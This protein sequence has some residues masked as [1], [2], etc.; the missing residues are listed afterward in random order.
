MYSVQPSAWQE[1]VQSLVGARCYQ[2]ARA[3]T[4]YTHLTHIGHFQVRYSECYFLSF[5]L[6]VFLHVLPFVRRRRLSSPS[7]WWPAH[8]RRAVEGLA[9]G[10][11]LGKWIAP[12]VLGQPQ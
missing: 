5:A 1:C 9:G 8:I 2:Y 12:S 10:S 6:T 11:V 3:K 7:I 4:E